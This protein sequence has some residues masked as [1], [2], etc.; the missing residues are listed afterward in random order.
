MNCEN[1]KEV[2]I[3]RNGPVT[4]CRHDIR[5]CSAICKQSVL[6]AGDGICL[7]FGGHTMWVENKLR[8]SRLKDCLRATGHLLEDEDVDKP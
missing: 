6:S 4:W 1:T 2:E 7:L 8:Y 5:L 3:V